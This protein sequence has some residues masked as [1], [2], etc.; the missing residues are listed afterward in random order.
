MAKALISKADLKRIALQEIRAFPG[1]DHVISVE[2]ECET[3][4]PSGID[5][6]LYVI[7]SD[8][9][10]LDHIQYAVKIA[11]DRLKRQYDL[12]PDR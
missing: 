7:A 12:R 9:G 3:G 2:V 4:P 11:S 5:W 6:R 10:D 8:E 1:S